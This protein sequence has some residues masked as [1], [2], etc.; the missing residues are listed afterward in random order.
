MPDTA[1]AA[2]Q[3]L[4]L[5]NWRYVITGAALAAL[6]GLTL[7]AVGRLLDPFARWRMFRGTCCETDGNGTLTVRFTD[8]NRVQHIAAFHSDAPQ[9]AALQ[10]GDSVRIALRTELFVSGNYPAALADAALAGRNILLRTEQRALLRRT[11]L[12]ELLVQL[13]ICGIALAVFLFTMHRCFPDRA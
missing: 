6:L 10:P 7:R 1:F 9:A 4:R 13:V 5:G 2:V 11:L 3:L 12:R 8:G